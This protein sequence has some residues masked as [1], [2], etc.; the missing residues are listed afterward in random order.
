MVNLRL[1]Q[2]IRV[3]VAAT[4]FARYE[5]H[6]RLSIIP[7]LGAIKLDKLTSMHIANFY[8]AMEKAGESAANRKKVGKCLRQV[9]R[10]AVDMGQIPA[11][12]AQRVALPKAA[13][14]EIA[15]LDPSRVGRFL[16]EVKKDR[17]YALYV[18]AVDTGMRQGELFGLQWP[19]IDFESGSLSVVR[20]LENIGD[21]LRVKDVKTTASRRWIELSAFALSVLHEHRKRMLA[22]GHASGPVFCDTVGGHLRRSNF[23]RN[24]F[25][26]LL[27]RAGLPDIPFHALRHNCAMML[28]MA[29][30]SAKVVSERLGHARIQTTLDT[31]T[32]VLSTMQKRAAEKMDG[33]FQ[34]SQNQ[35]AQA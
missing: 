12:P 24:S 30:E 8:A 17:R 11:S 3:K 20:S 23:H 14:P 2:S 22:E 15:V 21:E 7:H 27:R 13:K 32:H 18:M 10:Y 26:Q 9:L 33:F 5:Q 6:V 19:D 31:Y 29:N 16:D 25:K 1:Q 28:L 4:T 35:A 34:Q